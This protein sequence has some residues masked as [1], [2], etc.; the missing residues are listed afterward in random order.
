MEEWEWKLV[1]TVLVVEGSSRGVY[2][3]ESSRWG[4]GGCGG[5]EWEWKLVVTVLV[6]EGSNRGVYT[7]D[8][9]RW[10]GGVGGGR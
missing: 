10:G 3:A 6:V 5:E 4:G 1:V 7:A 8:S 2:T 9:S